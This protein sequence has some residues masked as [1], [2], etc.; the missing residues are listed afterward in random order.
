[1]VVGSM[2]RASTAAKTPHS[3]EEFAVFEI[4]TA[5]QILCPSQDINCQRCQRRG[6]EPVKQLV[7]QDGRVPFR[8]WAAFEFDAHNRTIITAGQRI[9]QSG[10]LHCG[11]KIPSIWFPQYEQLISR[12]LHCGLVP[13]VEKKRR[14]ESVPKVCKLSQ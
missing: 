3:N 7:E 5:V 8:G 9:H 12:G 14:L 11:S 13:I 1:M 10:S 4:W 6:P 2:K